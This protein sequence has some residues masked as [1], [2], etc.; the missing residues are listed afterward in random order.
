MTYGANDCMEILDQVGFLSR[1][2]ERQLRQILHLAAVRQF[3]PVSCGAGRYF[4]ALSALIGVCGVNTYEGEAA[5][6]L[7][8]LLPVN[9]CYDPGNCY[10]Y[11]VDESSPMVV[12][13]GPLVRNAVDD[14]RHGVSNALISLRFHNAIVDVVRSMAHRLSRRMATRTIALSGGVFQN[15]YLL[16]QVETVLGADDFCVLTNRVLPQNDAC[17]SLGQIMVLANTIMKL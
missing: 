5:I 6:A 17:V 9:A 8:S 7:E 13:F 1:Y 16:S 4:D 12:D 14:L 3:S 2:G 10:P 11:S 15:A